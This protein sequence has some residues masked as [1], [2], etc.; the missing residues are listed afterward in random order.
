MHDDGAAVTRLAEF[1]GVAPDSADTFWTYRAVEEAGRGMEV[2]VVLRAGW[3][4][5]SSA[6]ADLGAT[7]LACRMFCHFGC[8]SFPH[9]HAVLRSLAGWRRRGDDRYAYWTTDLAN[10]FT[11][12]IWL[13]HMFTYP[14]LSGGRPWDDWLRYTLRR[15]NTDLQDRGVHFRII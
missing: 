9:N 10:G 5:T 12:P 4:G 13:T 2:H 3:T 1:L 11:T 7:E 14:H 6:P 8:S 15:T